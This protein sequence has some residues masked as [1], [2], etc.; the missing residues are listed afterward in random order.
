MVFFQDAPR[1]LSSV[2]T[3]L[4][5]FFSLLENQTQNESFDWQPI[6]VQKLHAS[7]YHLLATTKECDRFDYL[8]VEHLNKNNS[9]NELFKHSRPL[10][11]YLEANSGMKVSNILDLVILYDT[12]SVELLKFKR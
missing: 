9:Y 8:M 11:N 2:K 5:G 1:I 4:A 12:L 6:Q 10:I 3:T 7:E